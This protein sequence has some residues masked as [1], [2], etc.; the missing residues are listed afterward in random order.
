[1]LRSCPAIRR[2]KVAAPDPTAPSSE[3]RPVDMTDLVMSTSS[4]PDLATRSPN[5]TC[6]AGIPPLRGVS[7]TVPS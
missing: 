6:S 2:L 5:G 3:P 4:N 7:V 1:M